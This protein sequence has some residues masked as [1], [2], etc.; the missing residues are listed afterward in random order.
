MRHLHPIR[1]SPVA[2]FLALLLLSLCPRLAAACDA[3][4]AGVLTVPSVVV[5]DIVYTNVT[6]SVGIGDV[7]AIGSAIANPSAATTPDFYDV[8]THL[9][10]VPCVVVGNTTFTNVVVSVPPDRVLSVGSSF[11]RPVAPRLVLAF[12]MADAVVGDAYASDVVVLVNPPPRTGYT[13]AID[14][15]ASGNTPTSMTLNMNGILSGT[16]FATGAADVNAYQVAHDYTFGVCAIDTLTRVATTPCP[17]TRVTVRPTNIQVTIVGAGTVSPSR[18]GNSCGAN[19]YEGFALHSS[20]TLTATPAAGSTFAGWSGACS[21]TGACVL[22]ASG[23]MAVTAT[24]TPAATGGLTGTWFG[25]VDQPGAPYDGCPAQTVSWSFTL[26]EGA[27][28]SITGTTQGGAQISATRSGNALTVTEY[29][30]QYA[31]TFGPYSW[32]WNGSNMITGT[33]LYYCYDL[34]SGALLSVGSSPFSVTR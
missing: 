28:G 1:R 24:F 31:R 33:A 26:T 22:S 34:S 23:S 5:G 10:T 3:W 12:P 11:V 4:A 8:A 2:L 25:T 20:V 15:L 13:F 27:N 18:A 29:V 16:P 7:Q 19:C 17:Q 6:L 32:T 14:T 30:A 21:G 9:L